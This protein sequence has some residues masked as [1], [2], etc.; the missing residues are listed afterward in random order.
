MVDLTY[1]CGIMNTSIPAGVHQL[2][3]HRFQNDYSEGAHPAIL[4]ALQESNLTQQAGYGE[5]EFSLEAAE[6]IRKEAENPQA[7]VHFLSGGTQINLTAL[8]ALMRPHESVIAAESGHIATHEAGAIEATGHK[9]NTVPAT[10]GKLT[11]EG[12]EKVVAEHY[13][14][15]MVLPRVV[16][17]SQSTELGTVYTEPEL[18][19]LRACCSALGLAIYVDGARLGVGL[20]SD[21]G[22]L[23]LAVFSR[24][25][26]VYTIGGTKNGALL[27]EALVIN[28]PELGV[29]FRYLMKQRGALLA[30]GRVVGIQ[31]QELFR[32]GLY[33]KLARQANETAQRLRD[34]LAAL[35]VPFLVDSPTNQIFPIFA[36]PVIG[37]LQ[38]KFAFY[39]WSRVDDRQQACRLV[40][41][42][43]TPL[44]RVELFLEEYRKVLTSV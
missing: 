26:D 23:S 2:I 10:D 37:R 11:P 38:E 24:Y 9:I 6:F 33:W 42:W 36:D 44:D 17:L 16:Y 3:L 27:G 25:V 15:H 1:G 13:F 34:G 4:L 5:D 39:T 22:A 29:H 41:S 14:E 19:A 40:T 8:S 30:K 7:E 12:I 31:F 20:T 43:A 28:R 32:S 21:A 18:A 35:G